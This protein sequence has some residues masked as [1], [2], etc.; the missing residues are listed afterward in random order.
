MSHSFSRGM[1]VGAVIAGTY[2]LL[3]SPH[4]GKKNRQLLAQHFIRLQSI[5]K[6][7]HMHFTKGQKALT[8][9]TEEGFPKAQAFSQEIEGLIR[10]YQIE[11]SSDLKH[12]N[13][14]LVTLN[15][16]LEKH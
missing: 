16:H 5:V 10:N 4:S 8:Y 14:A 9:L 3:H 7:G 6:E 15:Q 2:V 12:L 11:I 1:I 13:K